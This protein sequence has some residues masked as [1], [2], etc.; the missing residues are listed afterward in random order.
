MTI[1]ITIK[2]ALGV[3]MS[4]ADVFFWANWI[5]VG[6]L[7]IGVICACAI[8]VSGSMR[9][10]TLKRE[11]SAASERIETLRNANLK[12]EEKLAPRQ[13][14]PEQQTLIAESLS[15]LATIAGVKQ[16][17]AVFP[18]SSSFESA[19]LA[20]EIAATLDAAGWDINRN[21]VTYGVPYSVS[22]VGLLTSSNP[23]AISTATALAKA[24]NDAGI[25]SFIIPTKRS[26][27]EEMKLPPARISSDPW[28]SQISIF[29]GDHP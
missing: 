18:T 10:A 5:G 29:V 6:A 8:A 27:C 23:R 21:S 13:L 4:A 24:L 17:V 26:G 19:H 3:E 1:G 14:S 11:L 9:D 2:K 16:S 22:G 20:D 28:C 15:T 25:A 7:A 12:L